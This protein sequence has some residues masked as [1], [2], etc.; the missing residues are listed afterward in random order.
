MRRAAHRDET[1]RK[2]SPRAKRSQ[3]VRFPEVA[4][5]TL[6]FVELWLED[7][8]ERYIE[9]CFSDHTALVFA[10]RPYP[11]VK[12]ST[13]YGKWKAGNWKKIG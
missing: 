13:E 2:I 7:D 10:V 5:K 8:D 1:A 6:E 4:G 3:G 12:V 11:G 9:L